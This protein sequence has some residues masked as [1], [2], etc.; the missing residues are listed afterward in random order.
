M[1][2]SKLKYLYDAGRNILQYTRGVRVLDKLNKRGVKFRLQDQR[3]NLQVQ[4]KTYMIIAEN[5]MIIAEK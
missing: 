5:Y 1:L 3:R 2:S 4:N